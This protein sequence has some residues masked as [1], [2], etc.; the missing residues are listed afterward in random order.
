M[1]QDLQEKMFLAIN[2]LTEKVKFLYIEREQQSVQQTQAMGAQDSECDDLHDR[3]RAP[4]EPIPEE[5]K[6]E[7]IYVCQKILGMKYTL[8]PLNETATPAKLKDLTTRIK[9]NNDL[10]FAHLMRELLSD[11]ASNITHAIIKNLHK[12]MELPGRN[13]YS[14]APSVAHTTQ[15]VIQTSA[16]TANNAQTRTTRYVLGRLGQTHK[17]QVA[18]KYSVEDIQDSVQKSESREVKGYDEEKLYKFQRNKCRSYW[19]ITKCEA[20]YSGKFKYFL[21]KEAKFTKNKQGSQRRNN[22]GSRG[23]PSKKCNRAEDRR[24]KSSSSSPKTQQLCRGEKF[25]NRI[26]DIHMQDNQDKGL[27]DLSGSRG[28]F[29]AH[30]DTSEVQE[31]SSFSIKREDL[32]IFTKLGSISWNQSIDIFEQPFNNRQVQGKMYGEYKKIILQT[33]PT[34]VQGQDGEVQYDTISINYSSGDNNNSQTM[35]LKVP[36]DKKL[37]KLYWKDTSNVGCSPP[38]LPNAEKTFGIEKQFLK[39]SKIMGCHNDSEQS[40]NSELRILETDGVS[41]SVLVYSDNTTTLAY[42]QKFSGTTS[43]KLIEVS[44]KLWLHENK[45]TLPDVLCTNVNQPG[46]R[47]IKTDSSNKMVSI[48]R[49]IKE[50]EQNI[51]LIKRGFVCNKTEQEDVQKLQLSPVE[52]NT[53]DPTESSTGK[54]KYSSNYSNVEVCN[55]VSNFGKNQNSRAHTN[56]GVGDYARPKKR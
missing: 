56:T 8:P 49:D 39:E 23:S 2:S 38:W 3:V 27:Y 24:T 6:K 54:D 52:Y 19:I 26:P 50:T 33:K 51:W 17:Q 37:G 7:I 5:E 30:S 45:H 48:N 4:M 1:E 13:A 32:P 41:R 42:V 21:Q 25:Q 20:T 12:S 44:E 28:R 43:P 47:A 55:L 15:N 11:V 18:Q 9:D 29:Y 35:S 31:I 10:E 22:Q 34:G 40:N 46:R 16:N 36:S 53:T 14:T